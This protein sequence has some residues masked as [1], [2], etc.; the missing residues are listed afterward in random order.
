MGSTQRFGSLGEGSSRVLNQCPFRRKL[1]EERRKGDILWAVAVRMS[2]SQFDKMPAFFSLFF[3]GCQ[4]DLLLST[5]ST[6]ASNKMRKRRKTCSLLRL[7]L[8]SWYFDLLGGSLNW[9]SKMILL[10]TS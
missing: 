10:G 3:H 5:G 9:Q 7:Y 2:R 4:L 1:S 6:F 8:K